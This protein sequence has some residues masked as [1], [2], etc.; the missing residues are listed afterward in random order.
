MT[1]N[2][3]KNLQP[4]LRLASRM[5]NVSLN[6]ALRSW[7]ACHAE[8]RRKRGLARRLL[9]IEGARDALPA[10]AAKAL[11]LPAR[12]RVPLEGRLALGAVGVEGERRGALVQT[13]PLVA[14][15]AHRRMQPLI[16][17]VG[18]EWPN[19]RQ[20]VRDADEAPVESEE[21]LP[22]GQVHAAADGVA[23]ADAAGGSIGVGQEEVTLV[24]KKASAAER[25][26]TMKLP[27]EQSMKP[28]R[29]GPTW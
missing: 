17:H 3:S 26:S 16:E 22:G 28:T 5:L 23:R 2:Q 10:L 4:I 9:R 24:H 18:L 7:Q 6:R 21:D 15:D 14:D 19:G 11:A 13:D 25:G 8:L 12:P 20:R 1:T 27:G 29:V